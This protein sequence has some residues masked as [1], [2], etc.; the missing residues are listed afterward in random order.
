MPVVFQEREEEVLFLKLKTYRRVLDLNLNTSLGLDAFLMWG[1]IILQGLQRTSLPINQALTRLSPPPPWR[2][3]FPRSPKR[4]SGFL[5]FFF[6]CKRKNEELSE[7]QP[8]MCW[9]EM[10]VSAPDSVA[11]GLPTWV[12]IQMLGYGALF[13]LLLWKTYQ[14]F[15]AMSN[16]AS[17][18]GW[19]N[20]ALL[21]SC[22]NLKK[23][24]LQSA[25]EKVVTT[26]L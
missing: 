6:F 20:Q 25:R 12:W 18:T 22:Q 9:S 4:D 3:I 21:Q 2:K 5:F 23:Q 19:G 17:M 11:E 15:I 10:P 7:W 16:G 14:C 13:F 26:S 24:V 8:A 1:G